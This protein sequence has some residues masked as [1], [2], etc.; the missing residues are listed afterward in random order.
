MVKKYVIKRLLFKDKEF[1]QSKGHGL[2]LTD[3]LMPLDYVSEEKL[4]LEGNSETT[5]GYQYL[6]ENC[7]EYAGAEDDL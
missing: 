6:K 1:R 2:R 3:I 7:E 5:L 4:K